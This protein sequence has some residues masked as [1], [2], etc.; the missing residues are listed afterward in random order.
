MLTLEIILIDMGK[1]LFTNNQDW[2][3]ILRGIYSKNELNKNYI[4]LVC[5]LWKNNWKWNIKR[6]YKGVRYLYKYT[7]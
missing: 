3:N 7:R 2:E 4:Y 5:N 6:I 1:L